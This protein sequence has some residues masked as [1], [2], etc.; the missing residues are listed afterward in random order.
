VNKK[1]NCFL[2]F[3]PFGES[4]FVVQARTSF[5]VGE[6]GKME[7]RGDLQLVTSDH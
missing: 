1:K 3:S 6:N 7:N 2:H 4:F 5:R